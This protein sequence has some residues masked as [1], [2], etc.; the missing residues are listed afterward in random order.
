MDSQ[1]IQELKIEDLVLW[2]ENP[3]DPISPD[4][5]DQDVADKAFENADN[6][7]DLKKLITEMGDY[8]DY[9]ELPIVVMEKGKPIVFDG[10]RRIL[11]GKIK[12]GMVE[13]PEEYDLDISKIPVFPDVLPCNVCSREIALKS[14]CRK[15]SEI[16]TWDVLGRD[17]FMYKYMKE[18]KSP[19][20]IVDE[21][22]GLIRGNSSM[23]KRFV[24][25]EILTESVLERLGFKI[26]DGRLT[27]NLTEEG[28][29]R[30][31][32]D[33]K[34][35]INNKTFTTRKNRYKIY[36]NLDEA[37][38]KLIENRKNSPYKDVVPVTGNPYATSSNVSK[39][40]KRTKN[41]DLPLFGD[42]LVLKSGNANDLYRDISSMGEYYLLNKE[43]LSNKFPALLRM[44]LRL[45]AETAGKD[46][47]MTTDKYIES[48]F[49][50]A[51]KLLTQD[52]KTS[53]SSNSV[54]KNSIVQLLNIG[55]H[56]YTDSKSY[57]KAYAMSLIIGKML[58][59]SHKKR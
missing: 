36:E 57:D 51:R 10:N 49:D 34:E 45:L 1:K 22:T 38:R 31:W 19:F 32:E 59:I 26:V 55:A 46:V 14:V 54:S 29:K 47:N 4:S 2:T 25:D 12:K 37:T 18:S 58:S 13:V 7:W 35:K 11:L 21:Y 15:H 41:K 6:R 17:I 52:E 16:G 9:S 23:N 43:K 8:Y 48:Y 42:P 33:L 40:T 30:V 56:N 24:K 53:L 44:S 28:Q 3:R 5:N 27:S 39:R 50:E 20:L